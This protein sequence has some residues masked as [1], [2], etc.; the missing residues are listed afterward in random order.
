MRHILKE[1]NMTSEIVYIVGNKYKEFSK[2]SSAMTVAEALKLTN[3]FQADRDK[4]II[5]RIGQ[6]VSTKDATQLNLAIQGQ[7]LQ[8]FFEIENLTAVV[9]EREKGDIVHKRKQ[10]NIMITTPTKVA[11]NH[12]HGFLAMD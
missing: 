6:G 1:R 10:E 11:D 9:D 8:K 7:R 2:N 12:F 5:Y 4:K 3:I